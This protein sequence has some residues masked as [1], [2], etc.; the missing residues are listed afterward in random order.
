MDIAVLIKVVPNLERLHFDPARKTV[1]REG[2]ELFTNPFDQRA[3]RLALDL[4][5]P[6]ERVTVLSMGPPPAET[7]LREALALG[8]DAAILVTDRALAGSDTLVTAR[9][10]A[11]AL[12]RAG[13]DLVL[14]GTWSTDSETGQVGG[15]VAALLG[16]PAVTGAQ[17]LVRDAGDGLSAMVD[18]PGGIESW[19]LDAPAVVTVGEKIATIR[20]P[21]ATELDAVR[22]RPVPRLSAADL[23]FAPSEVGLEGSPTIV[24]TLRNDEPVRSRLCFQDGTI[25][26][27]VRAAVEV[28]RPLLGHPPAAEPAWPPLPVPREPSAEVLVLVTGREGTLDPAGPAMVAEVR[29]SLA[30]CWPTAVWAGP[31][32]APADRD[33]LAAAGAA[34][35]RALAL[36]APVDPR[37]VAE[38]MRP[39]TARA[40][41]P[42]AGLFSSTDFGR[43]V[44][45]TLAAGEKLGL[46]GDVVGV[47]SRADGGVEW[48]KPSFGGGMIAMIRTRT[49]P[50]L[51]TVRDGAFRPP[52]SAAPAPIETVAL[53]LPGPDRAGPERTGVTV[54]P[55]GAWGDLARAHI[56]LTVGAG[57]GGPE[58]LAEIA[59]TLDRWGAALGASRRV[60]DAGWLPRSRQLGLTG[61]S[62]APVLGVLLGISGSSNHRVAYRRARAL[63]AV[64][65]DPR[66]PVFR[67]VDAGIVGRWEEV[68]PPLTAAV[69]ALGIARGPA[70]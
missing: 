12:G 30:P 16:V 14:A 39:L 67:G 11:R 47:R 21:S 35:V 65:P 22:A 63:L 20:K 24:T 70:A 48:E 23:G 58:R 15:E 55:A 64:H 59:P 27:R 53:D 34:Q 29:R 56:V 57:L 52:P 50:S 2:A 44:A 41:P 26:E 3:V 19:R 32:L 60:V 8:A 6:G 69:E 7:A 4:R 68:L 66:A 51:A 62:V 38:A 45:A 13:H 25:E 37:R 36:P 10:L 54:E 46:V 1:V 5:R 43:G 17:S 40:S 49:V 31:A 9:V 28:L 61:R 42:A 18:A 33:A